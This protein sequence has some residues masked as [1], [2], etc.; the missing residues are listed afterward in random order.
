MLAATTRSHMT[1]RLA[2]AEIASRQPESTVR[3]LFERFLP[4]ERR[5]KRLGNNVN[6]AALV[7]DDGACRQGP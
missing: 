3:D 5:V 7:D 4:V 6:A 1:S 2:V